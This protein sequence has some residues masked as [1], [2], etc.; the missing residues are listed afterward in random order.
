MTIAYIRFS[1]NSQDETQQRFA[2]DEYVKQHGLEIDEFVTDEGVSGGVSYRERKLYKL[3]CRM[4]AGDTLITTEISRLGRSLGDLNML[5][6]QE[7]KPRKLRLIVVKM[8]LDLDCANLKA[9]DEMVIF[10]FGFA[11]ACEKEMIQQRTQSALDARKELLRT[12]GGFFSKN[13]NW[14]THL[15]RA[16][17]HDMPEARRVA[18]MARTQQAHSWRMDSPLYIWVENQVYKGRPRKDILA[19]ALELYD[20]NPDKYCTREGKALCKGTLSR[21]VREIQKS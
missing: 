11:A 13:G 5:V 4:K 10:A 19:E 7:M 20:K 16:K 9:V 14:T 3:I 17:G 8:G 12:E 21:W 6:T 18:C 15:G 1:T 2:L